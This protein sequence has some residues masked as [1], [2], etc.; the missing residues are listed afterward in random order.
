MEPLE[1]RR[2]R[3]LGRR[4]RTASVEVQSLEPRH[5]LTFSPLYFGLPDLTVEGIAAPVAAYGEDLAVTVTV[6]NLGTSSFVEPLALEPNAPSSA[7]APPSDVGVYISR[8]PRFGPGAI[9]IGDVAIPTVRQNSYVQVTDTVT[10]PSR[11]RGLPPNGGQIY[12]YFRTDINRAVIDQDRT[13][14]TTLQGVP[15]QIAAPLPELVGQAIDVPPVMQP[16]DAI[17]PVIKIANYG[18]TDP[19][20][21][22]T[23]FNV[24]LVASTDPFFGP[25][26]Q[27]LTTYTVDSVPPLSLA[28]MQRAVL[29][30]VNI[31][32]PVNVITLPTQLVALPLSPAQ[33]YIGVI[34][35]P[36]NVIREISEIGR[37]PDPSLN[38]IRP[39]GPPIPG[40]P[41]AGQVALP[42]NPENVFPYG[43]YGPL[44]TVYGDF[45]NSEVTVVGA[46]TS[47]TKAAANRASI[48]S[49]YRAA[50]PSGIAANRA[51]SL[52]NGVLYT[53]RA[54]RENRPEAEDS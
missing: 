54:H 6:R 48:P 29:G 5:L 53:I 16:G 25:G 34:V 8:F 38:P 45:L 27:V 13:N 37:G 33:Y 1:V 52:R 15:V 40:L 51:S 7:D 4:V 12:V 47:F 42:S 3:R 35:D 17:A 43:P 31:D 36:E 32:D 21:Q 26:D 22:A 19:D 44:P 14:N 10:M 50:F 39:V 28:P 18:T 30:N 9:K 20:T 23:S 24:A 41:P 2:S 11:L 49:S 46:G